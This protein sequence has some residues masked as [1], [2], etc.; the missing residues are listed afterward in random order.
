MDHPTV[1][2]VER[3]GYPFKELKMDSR[4]FPLQSGDAFLELNDATF[5]VE[6]ISFETE[7]A[8]E[9]AGAVRRY[10]E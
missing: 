10:V 9:I 5:A 2:K 1:T 6:G 3:T 4:G 8:L 7:E